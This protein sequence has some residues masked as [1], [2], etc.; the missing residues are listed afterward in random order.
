MCC[1]GRIEEIL[2]GK[3]FFQAFP[4]TNRKAGLTE[5]SDIDFSVLL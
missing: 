1:S 5:L 2:T 3:E 4:Q